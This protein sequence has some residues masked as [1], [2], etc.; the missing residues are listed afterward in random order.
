[1]HVHARPRATSAAGRCG[2]TLTST[3]R[4][5]RTYAGAVV[6][7]SPKESIETRFGGETPMLESAAG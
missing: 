6:V 2:R 7:Q 5:V 1:M 3:D 4:R